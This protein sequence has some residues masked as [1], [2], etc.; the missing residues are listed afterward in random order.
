MIPSRLGQTFRFP[1]QLLLAKTITLST[2][3]R[4]FHN[5]K[6]NLITLDDHGSSIAREIDIFI[7]DPHEAYVMI[8]KNVGDAFKSSVIQQ[9]GLSK[10]AETDTMPLTFHHKTRHFAPSKQIPLYPGG[11]IN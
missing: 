4:A 8:D 11:P 2:C 1:T 5:A 3:G 9:T 7:G 10:T 6:A